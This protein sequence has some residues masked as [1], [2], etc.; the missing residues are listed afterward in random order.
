MKKQILVFLIVF[1][2]ISCKDSNKIEREN[3]PAIYSVKSEDQE[4]NQA[5]TK[6]NQTLN[7]FNT[8]LSNHNASNQALKV[9]FTNA[10]GTE[11]MW[12]GTIE[13][14]DGKYSGILNNEPEFV[15]E[16]KSGDTIEIDASKISDWMYLENGKLFGGY[17][18]KVLRNRMSEEERKQFDAESGMQID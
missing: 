6:A 18:I 5:M 15:K 2:L 4:M 14:K 9:A 8:G 17:T 1:S 12:I 13:L 3:E 7:D 10:Q 11:H 16:Y